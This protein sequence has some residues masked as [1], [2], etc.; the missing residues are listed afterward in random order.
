MAILR[1]DQS[2]L[3]Y[4]AEA[5]QGGDIELS[6]GNRVTSS[7][8]TTTTDGAVN[9]GDIKITVDSVSNLTNGDFI[10]IGGKDADNTVIGDDFGDVTVSTTPDVTEFE[11]RRVVN[12]DGSV[13]TLDRPLGFAHLDEENVEEVDGVSAVANTSYSYITKVPGVYESVSVPDMT[14]TIDPRYYLGTAAKRQAAEFYAGQQSYS[15]SLGGMVLLDANPLRF[16]IGKMITDPSTY[17]SSSDYTGTIQV[18]A[19]KGDVFL[20][21]S[22]ETNLDKDGYL[23]ITDESGTAPSG[24]SPTTSGTNREV[25]RVKRKS[26]ATGTSTMVQLYEP[27]RFDHAAGVNVQEVGT[28]PTYTHVITPENDLDTITWHL[29][30]KDSSETDANDFDRRYYGGM[31]DSASISG[32]EGGLLTFGWDTVNFMGMVHNQKNQATVGTTLFNGDSAGAGMPKFSVMNSITAS[33]IDFPANNPYYFSQGVI[34][35]FGEE[36]A[37]IRSF[38]ITINNA[39]EPRYYIT[40]RHGR[41]RGPSE[42]REGRKSY[43]MSCTLALPDTV[44]STASTYTGDTGA[45][46]V[47]KQLILEGNYGAAAGMNGFAVQVKFTRGTNDTITIDIPGDGTANTGLNNQ[48]AFITSAPHNITGDGSALQVDV[49][50]VFRDLKITVVDSQGNY[51]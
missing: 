19:K 18:E 40:G 12:I 28:S 39:T 47:F 49:D 23:H 11:I 37:R 17:L 4:T 20:N 3:T 8:F 7:N 21:L 1:S 14:P 42:I 43:S 29:H 2:Q 33:D 38:N 32:E 44:A 24:T 31:V 35:L 22:T 5:A 13:L 25:V 27:L 30:M 50:M 41:N 9:A 16:P 48:G 36:I 6:S 10:R 51:A 15:G 26:T 34:K 45:L 46:E